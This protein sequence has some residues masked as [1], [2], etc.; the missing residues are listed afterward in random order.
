MAALLS[1]QR[2]DGLEAPSQGGAP[3]ALPAFQNLGGGQKTW[4]GSLRTPVGPQGGSQ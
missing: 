2:Q 1:W 4:E 3:P